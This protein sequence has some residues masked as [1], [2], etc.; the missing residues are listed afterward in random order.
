MGLWPHFNEARNV[1]RSLGFWRARPLFRPPTHLFASRPVPLL[2]LS[3][4]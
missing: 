2:L 3:H 1:I 4:L